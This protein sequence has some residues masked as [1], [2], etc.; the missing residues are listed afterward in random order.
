[1]TSKRRKKMSR[2]G[3][4]P[5]A[6]PDGVEVKIEGNLLTAKGPKGTES[7]E[8]PAEIEVVI[9]EKEVAV[10]YEAV[11]GSRDRIVKNIVLLSNKNNETKIDFDEIIE[12]D[13]DSIE[14][15]TDTTHTRTAK[16]SYDADAK[17]LLNGIAT[18]YTIEEILDDNISKTGYINLLSSSSSRAGVAIIRTYNMM[19]LLR[20][21]KQQY[22]IYAKNN[23]PTHPND[24]MVVDIYDTNKRISI[25]RN[26]SDYAFESLRENHILLISES[27][28]H[29]NIEVLVSDK[30]ASGTIAY[31]YSDPDR[32]I[33]SSGNTAYI[34]SGD[35]YNENGD[36]ETGKTVS[37]S[38]DAFGKVARTVAVAEA[39]FAEVLF[40]TFRPNINA[41]KIRIAMYFIL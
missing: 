15:Y 13:G 35:I 4:L 41:S 33:L 27:A 5:I 7:V 14:Y 16:A 22:K 17:I 1:M 40:P 18:E 3:K 12:Y 25:K 34:I 20:T 9:N 24:G 32:I 11:E 10:Y 31:K 28:D 6:I 21:D 38:L 23:S 8:F 30:T 37:I 36:I 19:V 26:G 39:L 2:I 29:K